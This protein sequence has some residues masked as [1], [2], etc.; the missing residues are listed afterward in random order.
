LRVFFPPSVS[1]IKPPSTIRLVV[2]LR[3]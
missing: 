1:P 3:M 2:F